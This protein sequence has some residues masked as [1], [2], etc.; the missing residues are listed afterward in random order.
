MQNKKLK[1]FLKKTQPNSGFTLTELLAGLFMSIFVTG[2]LGFGLYQIMSATAREKAKTDARNEASRAVEFISDELRRAQSIE[3]DAGNANGQNASGNL[4]FD[5]TGKT[6]VLALNIP[7]INSNQM[8]D[9]NGDGTPGLLG[10]DDNNGT[11]ERIV[12]YLENSSGNWQGPQVLYRWGPPLNADGQ[13]TEGA[14]QAEALIDGIDDTVTTNPC[15]AAGEILTTNSASGFYAC[16]MDDDGDGVVEDGTVDTNGDGVIDALDSEDVDRAGITAQIYLTGGIDTIA[17]NGNAN[18]S[19]Y[20]AQTKAVAR[21]KVV[22]ANNAQARAVSP[23]TFRS[24]EADY[25]CNPA[26]TGSTWTMRTDF[27][28]SNYDPS[29]FN[30]DPSSSDYN[31]YGRSDAG[32]NRAT[33]WIHQPGR[34][35][36]P[37]D[38]TSDNDLT[39]HSIPVGRNTHPL[40]SFANGACLSTGN[41]LVNGFSDQSNLSDFVDNMNN[42]TDNDPNNNRLKSEIVSHTIK[43]KADVSTRPNDLGGSNDA[44]FWKS[45]NGDTTNGYDNPN[46][47]ADGTVQVLKDGSRLVPGA[48]IDTTSSTADAPL[49]SGYDFDGDGTPDRESLGEFL[50][51]KGFAEYINGNDATGGYRIINLES[52]ERIVAFEVGHTDTN[53]PGFDLQDNVFIMSHDA[54]ETEY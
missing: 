5:P 13:Y 10:S 48:A 42:D 21:A 51:N 54:F 24:L 43:F 17:N 3:A 23:V 14:W 31:P 1:K 26:G 25:V 18:D 52:G 27:D 35:A 38:I 6:I 34:Q 53:H 36:Q 4:L 45:F 16:L 32:M 11:S 33:R 40:A 41:S 30:P 49:Y 50:L 15:T 37:I 12:Y 39:I 46:V 9:R 20:T 29:A 44:D 7:E 22:D 8:F 19:N 2:A 47:K 28:N